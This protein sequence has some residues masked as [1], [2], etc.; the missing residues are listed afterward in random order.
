MNFKLAELLLDVELYRG[1]Y[2][3]CH[4]LRKKDYYEKWMNARLV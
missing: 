1:K 3:R 4:P 2:E